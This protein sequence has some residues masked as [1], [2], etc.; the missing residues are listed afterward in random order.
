[1]GVPASKTGCA[2]RL[3]S[4]ASESAEREGKK[5]RTRVRAGKQK[6]SVK[7]IKLKQ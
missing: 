4:T 7:E 1:M 3:N 6:A 5:E 2:G